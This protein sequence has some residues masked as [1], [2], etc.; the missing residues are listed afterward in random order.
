M[1]ALEEKGGAYILGILNMIKKEVQIM[2]GTVKLCALNPRLNRYFQENRFDEIF[3]IKT[4]IEQ[5]KRSFRRE[6][7]EGE[8]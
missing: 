3:E 7:G 6:T 2:G 1:S 5:A 8:N 4:S